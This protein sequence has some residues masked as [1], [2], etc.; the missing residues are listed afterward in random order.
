MFKN[1]LLYLLGAGGKAGKT[2]GLGNLL[3]LLDTTCFITLTRQNSKEATYNR[4][5]FD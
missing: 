5:A 4:L 3:F 2:R 1:Y